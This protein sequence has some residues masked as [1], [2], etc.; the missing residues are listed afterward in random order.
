[1]QSA[2]QLFPLAGIL[3]VIQLVEA[4]PDGAAGSFYL[5]IESVGIGFGQGSRVQR[6]PVYIGHTCLLGEEETKARMNY[7][8]D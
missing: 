5:A 8:S 1:V 6:L 7:S 4:F 3:G 2:V